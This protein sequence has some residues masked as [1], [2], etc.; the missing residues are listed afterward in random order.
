MAT[1]AEKISR[2]L[3]IMINAEENWDGPSV[4]P[5]DLTSEQIDW[6]GAALASEG[7]RAD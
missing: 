5:N 3:R 7:V 4:K 6:I 1:D 2:A